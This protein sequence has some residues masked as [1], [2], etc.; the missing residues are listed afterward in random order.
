MFDLFDNHLIVLS[1]LNH[2]EQIL[3]SDMFD[4]FY[5][6]LTVPFFCILVS[7][8]TLSALEIE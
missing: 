4:L 1:Y 8:S 3:Y 7:C 5:T 2:V 6:S